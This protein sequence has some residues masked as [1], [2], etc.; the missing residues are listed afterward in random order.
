[1]VGKRELS[2]EFTASA[3][4]KPH[5]FRMKKLYNI[6]LFVLFFNQ[7]HLYAQQ[8][9]ERIFVQTDRDYY[10]PGETISFNGFILSDIDSVSSRNLFVELWSDS[11]RQLA[12]LTLPLIDGAGAGAIQIPREIKSSLYFLRAYTD[13]TALQTQPYQFVKTL[14]RSAIDNP[15][16]NEI[17]GNGSPVFYPEGGALVN[18]A[19]N[20]VVFKAGNG[21]RGS[22]RNSK[23]DTLA[24]LNPVFNGMGTFT[25]VPVKGETYTCYW[26]EK[27]RKGASALPSAVD[28]GIALHIRQSPDT[29]FIDLD[30]GGSP[31]PLAHQ[32][33]MLL[34][35]GNEPAYV[36]EMNLSKQSKFSYFIPLQDYR[37]GM[38]ELRVLATDN[39]V[40]ASRPVFINRHSFTYIPEIELVNKNFSPRAENRL[41]LQF[42]DSTIRLL[43]VSVTDA[44][45]ST[46]NNGSGLA[47]SFLSSDGH[48]LPAA[49]RNINKTEQL[50]LAVQVSGFPQGATDKSQ[51]KKVLLAANYLQLKGTVL[52][53]KKL[54]ADKNL[55]VG[56]RTASN[57][58]ELYKVKTD[59]QG[60]F[61]IND[62]VLFGDIYV[63]CRIPGNEAQELTC[64]FNL[65]TPETKT[66]SDFFD[67][68]VQLV[69]N[70]THPLLAGKNAVGI[71]AA[72]PDPADTLAF[73]E[74][75]ITLSE[76][77]LSSSSSARA[78]QRLKALE[79]KYI[80]G[81]AFSGYYAT[82][83]TLDVLNDPDRNMYLDLFKYMNAKLKRTI[84]R[85]GNGVP[86]LFYPGGRGINGEIMITLYYIDNSIVDRNQLDFIS[87]DQV[88]AIKFVPYLAIGK[89]LPPAV[90]VFLK[91][92]GDE[93]YWEKDRFQV[94]EQ[95]LTGYPVSQEFREPDYRK[96]ETRVDKDLRKTINWKPNTYLEKGETEI[97]FYNNDRTKKIRIIV[98]GMAD[99]GSLIYFEKEI[100]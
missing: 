72:T 29:M 58:K 51:Q 90:A 62:L 91:K 1:M 57:G 76:V 63:H 19:L 71:N 12:S 100:E 40:L 3:L 10:A 94:L 25:I 26:E 84:L 20:H 50:D 6:I 68:F 32:L 70:T 7:I 95:K 16:V 82:S 87:L 92:P 38:A 49:F 17:A 5:S 52:K 44:A 86:Q 83:E 78:T 69:K 97:H 43:S 22:V 33:K 53:G 80:N 64:T 66:S 21:F 74:K 47:A 46:G 75:S 73:T 39:T 18:Q 42:A 93:G 24:T 37:S 13:I 77:M 30:N 60:K 81:S 34:M 85:Y 2:A 98:E 89:E 4:F 55:F 48:P 96:E 56:I 8:S 31:D 36:V 11:L 54:L 79:D 88:A 27:D 99:D 14:S 15:A 67:R 9:S 45:Y 28:I 35:I 65:I 61:V 23:G 59:E 41:R